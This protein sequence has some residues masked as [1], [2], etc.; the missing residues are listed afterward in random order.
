MREIR[1]SGLMSGNGKRDGPSRVSTRA[2]S[3]LYCLP[4]LPRTEFSSQ[5]VLCAKFGEVCALIPELYAEPQSAAAV[6]SANS[7]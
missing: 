3:R 1:T 5:N 7:C 6:F 2:H 4:F